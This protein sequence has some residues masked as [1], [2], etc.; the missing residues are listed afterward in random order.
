MKSQARKASRSN[1]SSTSQSKKT[2]GVEV[3]LEL[4]QKQGLALLTPATELGYG[5]AAGGGKS[6]LGRAS[7]IYFC[8]NIPGLQVYFFRRTHNELEKNHMKGPT[9]FP[10]MLAPWVRSGFVK[11]VKNEIRFANGEGPDPFELGSRI[12]MCHCQHEKDVFNWLGPEMHYLI[13][14]QAE[15]FTPFM[16]EMLRSRNRI[17]D[18]LNIPDEFKALFPRC[19][20]TFNPG[21]VGHVFFKS[22]FFRALERGAD[23]ISA[24]VEQPD[25]EGGKKRQFIQAKLHDNPSVNP[26]QY[27]KTLSGL[28]AKMRKALLDGDFE[29]VLGA[30]FPQISRALH[31]VKPFAI[32]SWWPKFMVMDYGAC[33]D[34]DP[35]SIGWY[36]IADGTIPVTSAHTGDSIP[37]QRDSLICYRR[38]N[39]RGLPK[40]D[41]KR[42]ADGIKERE[43]EAIIYRIAGGDILEQRGHGESIFDIFLANGINFKAADNRRLNGWGQVDY[44]L[45]GEN[46]YPLSF[47]FEECEDDLETIGALQ[48]D[49]VDGSDIAK[50]DDHDADRHRYA[51]TSRPVAVDRPAQKLPPAKGFAT[52]TPKTI[53]EQQ[54]RVKR[55]AR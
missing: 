26:E 47:W 55:S 7:A 8:Y 27:K 3:H 53:L 50:G 37:C 31:L 45:T 35:F 38:W 30:F 25:E 20:Y 19:L 34:G 44:R 12:F 46:G 43:R 32:P 54:R 36:A 10:A 9:S 49:V 42:I 15:Q 6:H 1:R 48:H 28:P 40:M 33:G 24:I 11:I 41:A 13:I 5:G 4:H 18:A 52:L 39:G 23:G 51:C 17:P 29:A 16:I 21:G 22:K 2:D 14:E